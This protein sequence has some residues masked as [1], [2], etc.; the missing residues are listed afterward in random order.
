MKNV[1]L[2][3]N[4]GAPFDIAKICETLDDRLREHR[5]VPCSKQEE[6]RMGFIPPWPG[7]DLDSSKELDSMTWHIGSGG[8]IGLAFRHEV[9]RLP[10]STV[11]EMTEKRIK[12][13]EASNIMGRRLSRN[14]REDVKDEV[15]LELLANAPSSFSHYA[16]AIAPSFI[17][18]GMPSY[19]RAEPLLNMVREVLGS[20]PVVP[21]RVMQSP[22]SVMTGWLNDEAW[23][24]DNVMI[25][26]GCDLKD[27]GDGSVSIRKQELDGDEVSIHLKAGKK[28]TGLQLHWNDALSFWM[29]D[30]MSMQRLNWSDAVSDQFEGTG[31][32]TL[33]HEFE[34]VFIIEL[35]MLRR[36]HEQIPAW[37]SNPYELAPEIPEDDLSPI[38]KTA[39]ARIQRISEASMAAQGDYEQKLLNDAADRVSAMAASIG[40]KTGQVEA[41]YA[42]IE[43]EGW[44]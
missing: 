43:R 26:D 33:R 21:L 3:T 29:K 41:T 13:K 42:D 20:L 10:P 28:V 30:D 5:Y 4:T 37:F 11:K 18:V 17:A 32:E 9:K 6:T 2:Y 36:L 12:E 38:S 16:M 7:I 25:G 31:L 40:M 23:K 8:A 44:K 35:D 19:S 27:H 15:K 22:S 14:E 1:V 34:A 39:R 24:P